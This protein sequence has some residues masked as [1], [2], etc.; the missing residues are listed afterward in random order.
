MRVTPRD[1]TGQQPSLG[2]V[3][4]RPRQPVVEAAL[5]AAGQHLSALIG[6]QIE[7]GGDG[8]TQRRADPIF[9]VGVHL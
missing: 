4:Q 3:R 2:K 1:G 8:I 9:A 5:I 7:P 6:S